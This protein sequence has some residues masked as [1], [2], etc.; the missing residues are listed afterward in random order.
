M[1]AILESMPG[2][3]LRNAGP[4]SRLARPD[5]VSRWQPTAPPPNCSLGRPHSGRRPMAVWERGRA[6]P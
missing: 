6:V 5:G 3:A 4:R 2:P 1:L